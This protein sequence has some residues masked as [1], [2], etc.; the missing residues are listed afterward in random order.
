MSIVLQHSISQEAYQFI[1]GRVYAH[2]R[3]QLGPDKQ[4]LV[5]GRLGKRLR[6]LGLA[7]FDGYCEL[8]ESDRGAQELG[9]L[10]DLISTNHTHFFRETQ[11]LDFLHTHILSEWVPRLIGRGEAFRFW[12]AACSSGEEP[13][14]VAIVLAEYARKHGAFQWQIEASDIS[15][16]ILER[17]EQGVYPEDRV[18]VPEPDLLPRYFQKG[19][20]SQAGLYRVKDSLRG[21]VT[22]HHLNLLQAS[23][24]V[25]RDQHVIFCRNVM[26]YFDQETQQQLVTKLTQ[27]ITHGGYLVVGHS[28]SLLG[29]RHALK[30]IKPGIYRRELT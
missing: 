28:E 14:T 24:P 9:A 26:I 17:A 19:A 13:Y 22:F 10:V 2:S 23:Y 18:K 15:T 4:A 3:I 12:S 1:A 11:H 29:I 20:G 30:Q 8:L 7:S 25:G 16:R 6:Q 5:A 21:S 27:Q